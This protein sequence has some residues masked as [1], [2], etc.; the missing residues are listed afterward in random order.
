MF[1]LIHKH[2]EDSGSAWN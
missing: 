2:E 1:D